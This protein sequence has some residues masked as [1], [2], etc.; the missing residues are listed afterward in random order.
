MTYRVGVAGVGRGVGPARMFDLMPDCKLVA[1]CDL[2]PEALQRFKTHFPDA[3]G[4]AD[5][6]E[7]LSDGLDIVMVG[8]PIPLHAEQTVA[9]LNAGCHVLQE[10]TLANTLEG[11]RAILEAV[12]AHPKQKFMLA[13]NCCY[14]AFVLAW[15]QMWK[16]GRL[17]EFMYA[18]AE[19]VHDIRSLLRNKDGT[20][21]WRAVRPPIIYCTH[22]LGPL[23]KVTGERCTSACC[24]HTGSK[25]EPDL[26]HLDFMVAIFQTSG[27]GVIKLLRA[28][29]VAREPAHHYYSLYGTKGCLETSRPPISPVQTNAYFEGIPHLHNLIQMPLGND[30]RGVPTAALQGGHGTVEYLMVQD[31][32]QS[33]R[34]DAQPP[35]DITAALDMTLPGLCAY[36]SALHGGKPV[37]IPAI[38]ELRFEN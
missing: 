18:E 6:E 22:S 28:Q 16:E 20:P 7:M 33:I 8:T 17:G 38:S 11:C 30:V 9:A 24:L 29:A 19:Y 25:L 3:K 32:M 35:I 5:Y 2:D 13:E 4:F 31:F 34:D 12:K 10:V 21:T 27:G 36:E 23:L 37:P 14:W 26:N 1:G 15:Q